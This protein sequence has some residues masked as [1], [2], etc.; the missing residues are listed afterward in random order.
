MGQKRWA[1]LIIIGLGVVLGLV[2]VLADTIGLG[3]TP[4]FGLKQTGGLLAGVALVI[5]GLWWKRRP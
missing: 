4:G 1:P 3:R 2:S 5:I